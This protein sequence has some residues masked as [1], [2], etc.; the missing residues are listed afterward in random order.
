MLYLP[1]LFLCGYLSFTRV[2]CKELKEQKKSW[3]LS[4]FI[5]SF[6]SY[7]AVFFAIPTLINSENTFLTVFSDSERA[8]S[9]CVAFISFCMFD[10][11]FG[12]LDYPSHF[13]KIEGLIHHIY[14]TIQLTVF[15]TLKISNCFW[16]FSFCEIPTLLMAL[17]KLGFLTLSRRV[18]AGIFLI[19]RVILFLVVLIK[20]YLSGTSQILLFTVPPA[21]L[22]LI[23]HIWWSFKLIQKAS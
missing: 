14:Y 17:N 18:Y 21:V 16:V 5:T 1:C 15:L 4:L 2:C 12:V 7:E 13:S 22:C 8:R 23:L 19:F 9:S 6:L 20:Y 3:I 11:I 10:I